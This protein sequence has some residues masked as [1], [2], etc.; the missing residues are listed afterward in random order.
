MSRRGIVATTVA[1]AVAV[2]LALVGRIEGVRA[3]RAEQAGM[4]ASWASIGGSVTATRPSAYRLAPEFS[5]LF[6][7]RGPRPFALELCFDESGRLV[8]TILRLGGEPEVW[9]L[10]AEPSRTEI[11]IEP[12]D[13]VRA[14]QL[15]GGLEDVP[16]TTRAIPLGTDLG[17]I[18]P[19]SP[20]G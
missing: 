7:A 5:C 18:V 19:P 20:S 14:A 16:V 9:S 6:Y 15:I 10:R 8:E 11:V 1:A 4:R 3:A 2:A 13:F 12:G 17:P